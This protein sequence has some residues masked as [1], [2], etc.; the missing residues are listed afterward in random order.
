MHKKQASS[1]ASSTLP[2]QF[3][4]N[5]SKWATLRS[6]G[7]LLHKILALWRTRNS[8]T[9]QENAMRMSN[10]YLFIILY[11]IRSVIIFFFLFPTQSTQ[12][13]LKW[14]IALN[15]IKSLIHSTGVSGSTLFSSEVSNLTNRW[16]KFHNVWYTPTITYSVLSLLSIITITIQPAA[17]SL[18]AYGNTPNSNIVFELLTYI[19]QYICKSTIRYYQWGLWH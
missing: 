15:Y 16:W 8:T 5:G 19:I 1:P 11:D 10:Y 13:V 3:H 12:I 18:Q 17:F 4:L 2:W 6:N 7:I 14:I 9:C